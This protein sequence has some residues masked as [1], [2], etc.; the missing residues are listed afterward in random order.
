MA[1][2]NPTAP[3]ADSEPTEAELQTLTDEAPSS[4]A[5]SSLADPLQEANLQRE[6]QL[7]E[8]RLRAATV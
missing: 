7:G 8:D 2:K 1:E 6:L 5:C 3:C 4:T